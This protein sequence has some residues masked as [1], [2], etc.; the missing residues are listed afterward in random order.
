MSLVFLTGGARSG[1]S[2]LAVRIAAASGAPVTFVATGKA[3]DAEMAARIERHRRERPA[4][5]RTVEEP[6]ALERAIAAAGPEDCVLVDCL[7]L[8]VANLLGA[9][10]DPDEVLAA[11]SAVARLAAGRPGPAVVVSNEVGLGVVPAHAVA[12][13]YRDVLGAVNVVF[14]AAAGRAALVVA[15]RVLELGP[16]PAFVEECL[17]G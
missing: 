1:K 2:A 9:G 3:G 16:A 4:G 8:W 17:D 11:A 6:L 12:R 10:R 15:G 13:A 7:T 14:A 5:W